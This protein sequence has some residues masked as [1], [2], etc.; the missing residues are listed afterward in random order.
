MVRSPVV[1]AG[2]AHHVHAERVIGMTIVYSTST[3][4]EQLVLGV[5]F[6][7]FGYLFSERYR[8]ARGVTPWKIPAAVWALLLFL[9]WEIFSVL[10]LI[11]YFTTRPRTGSTGWTGQG[12]G[13]GQSGTSPS[14]WNAS[15]GEWGANRPQGWDAPVPGAWEVPPPGYQGAP[16]PGGWDAPPEP[17]SAFPG[18]PGPQP[19]GVGPDAVPPVPTPP[20]TP[21]AWLSDPSGHHELRYWDGTKFTEH[22]A[23]AGKITIDP[24]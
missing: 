11:A 22:V 18:Y 1:A 19:G 24:L 14:G 10:Y 5:I 4:V 6:G 15:T 23:D 3:I 8:R 13:P 20:P 9:S 2:Y 16:P 17:G 12:F 21:R 7:A